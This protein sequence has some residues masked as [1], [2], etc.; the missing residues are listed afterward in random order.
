MRSAL[1]LPSR[2]VM[3]LFEVGWIALRL[4]TSSHFNELLQQSLPESSANGMRCPVVLYLVGKVGRRG[5]DAS[6]LKVENEA[7]HHLY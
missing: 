5:L 1:V 2:Q 6:D 4:V 7:K 3:L